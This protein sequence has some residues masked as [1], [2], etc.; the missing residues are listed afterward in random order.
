MGKISDFEDARD[1]TYSHQLAELG[2]ATHVISA[3]VRRRATKWITRT[4]REAGAGGYG[5]RPRN[6]P[7]AWYDEH[8][9]R[10]LHG[11][12]MVNAFQA[13][14]P[15]EH[16]AARFMAAYQ[17]YR[18]VS[19]APILGINEAFEIVDLFQCGL[20]YTKSCCD[21]GTTYLLV[22]ERKHCPVCQWY[23]ALFCQSC[24][25]P[26]PEEFLSPR[27]GRPRLYCLKCEVN[28]QKNRRGRM[29]QSIPVGSAETSSIQYPVNF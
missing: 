8:A 20:A 17:V 26:L 11:W 2:A 23:S 13:N 21:C 18:E 9:E 14:R 16:P 24:G 12:V 3:L 7:S 1:V 19:G 25:D 6:D 29:Y 5:F 10:L 28:P 15:I 22:S 27:R 4:V